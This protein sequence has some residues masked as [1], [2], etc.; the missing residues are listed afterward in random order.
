[1]GG[2]VG[3]RHWS[4]SDISEVDAATNE[5]RISER[6]MNPAISRGELLY[7]LPE[8]HVLNAAFTHPGPYGG[9]FN[10]SRRGESSPSLAS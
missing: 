8:A 2:K 3:G 10:D 4:A 9:R 1:M 7:G 6:G 5:R